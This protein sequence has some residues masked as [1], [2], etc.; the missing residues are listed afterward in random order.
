MATEENKALVRRL[1]EEA[2]NGGNLAMEKLRAMTM[3]LGTGDGEKWIC[4]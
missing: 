3:A 1:I 2:W 4:A